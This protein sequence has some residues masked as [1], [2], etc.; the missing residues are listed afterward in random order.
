ML[1]N[2]LTNPIAVIG[3]LA[4]VSFPAFGAKAIL[5]SVGLIEAAVVVA[6]WRVFR[7]VLGWSNRRALTT[8]LI[9]NGLSFGLGL[10]IGNAF[11]LPL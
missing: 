6:E 10:V 2:T 11:G 1:V 5:L 8:S 4:V 3:V 7:W 9:A